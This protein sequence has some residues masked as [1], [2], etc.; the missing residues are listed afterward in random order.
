M[1]KVLYIE[2]D[3]DNL[4]ML[5]MRLE[6]IGDFEVLASNDSE[7]GCKLALTDRP[8]VILMDLEMPVVDRWEPVRTLKNDPQTRRIPCSASMTRPGAASPAPTA[9]PCGRAR[10]RTTHSRRPVQ[11]FRPVGGW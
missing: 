10:Q 11:P 7:Q 8:D 2:H 5:K 3:D 6:R 4:Y 1:N 9:C